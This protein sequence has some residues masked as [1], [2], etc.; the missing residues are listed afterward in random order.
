MCPAVH[1]SLTTKFFERD[2]D[3]DEEVTF[4]YRVKVTPDVG[5]STF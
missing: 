4:R 1:P 5:F 2:E 3:A